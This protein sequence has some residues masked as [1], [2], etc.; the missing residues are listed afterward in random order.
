MACRIAPTNTPGAYAWLH[1]EMFYNPNQV[2]RFGNQNFGD[3]VFGDQGGSGAPEWT[4]ITEFVGDLSLTRGQQRPAAFTP[5]D[6]LTFTAV[7]PL[8]N[9]LTWVPPQSLASPT[10]GTPCRAGWSIGTDTAPGGTV[11]W[12][13]TTI[14]DQIDELAD[15]PERSLTV[16]CLGAKSLLAT[17]LFFPDR[18]RESAQTRIAAVLADIGYPYPVVYDPIMSTIELEA[19]DGGTFRDGVAAFAST[20]IEEA[21]NSCGLQTYTDVDG[22]ILFATVGFRESG[23]PGFVVGNCDEP[24]I[25]VIAN[26]IQYRMDALEVLNV[27]QVVNRLDPTRSAEAI[28]PTSVAIYGR[29]ADGYG[30]PLTT[31]NQ[32]GTV[33]QQIADQIL[34]ETANIVNRVE[35]LQAN[36]LT[37]PRW[38]DIFTELTVFDAFTVRRL[39]PVADEFYAQMIG[40]SLTVQPNGAEIIIHTATP[41]GT[42]PFTP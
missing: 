15:V 18:P 35:G 10:I 39:E 31:V 11:R 36:T 40:F 2:R 28:D 21:A 23:P 19:D 6:T 16:S 1:V 4:D 22:T 38:W 8:G 20:V 41:Q 34:A 9:F 42:D 24:G 13:T 26:W 7:D 37:D 25:D 33:A 12:M 32:T 14:V 30:F 17:P 29:R 3:E 5:A 27:V